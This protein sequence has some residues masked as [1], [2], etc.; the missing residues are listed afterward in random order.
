MA[1]RIFI[2]LVP[3]LFGC[4]SF[5]KP[6]ERLV[7]GLQKWDT[8]DLAGA[9]STFESVCEMGE[10]AACG[11]LGD[12]Q[13]E[14]E[15][16][17][18]ATVS[19]QKGCDSGNSYACYRLGS[20]Y[21]RLGRL[22]EAK[23]LFTKSC[24]EVFNSCVYVGVV[25]LFQQDYTTAKNIFEAQ[26]KNSLP[27]SCLLAG[28]V[29][30][31]NGDYFSAKKFYEKSCALNSLGGCSYLA[32]V[33]FLIGNRD[34]AQLLVESACVNQSGGKACR[35]VELLKV[36][37][38]NRS[39]QTWK[40]QCDKEDRDAC[41]NLGLHKSLS[42]KSLA[43]GKRILKRSCS[44]GSG[45]AC[46]DLGGV[47]T[48]YH[49]SLENRQALV[50]ACNSG[51]ARGCLTI[52]DEFTF[53][54]GRQDYLRKACDLGDGEGCRRIAEHEL[55]TGKREEAKAKYLMACA[56]NDTLACFVRFK[57]FPQNG[58]EQMDGMKSLCNQGLRDGCRFLGDV[59]KK[60]GKI[61]LAAD[62]YGKGCNA[63]DERSCYRQ[64]AMKAKLDLRFD[65]LT[66]Y[67]QLCNHSSGYSCYEA[68]LLLE[69]AGRLV[70]AKPFV[71]RGCYLSDGSSCY[72]QGFIARS[73]K[74]EIKARE[75]YRRA[76]DLG[77]SLG[78]KSM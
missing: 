66:A 53:K 27:E 55:T 5:Q 62:F 15:E 7:S 26:C 32:F 30:E 68:A 29:A 10:R 18:S 60:A 37:K 23:A 28:A 69:E 41:Y 67:T 40:S 65:K 74:N 8:G 11:H 47:L 20:V 25:N 76:C 2:W 34:K 50:A 54:P 33:E 9:Q 39:L 49:Y 46:L 48:S 73:E 43:E 16:I 4:A 72:L 24:A 59:Y 35:V 57:E 12:I 51:S 17:Q 52:D 1:F 70:E 19:F 36:F 78:C 31:N 58:L 56:K 71:E 75:L 45:P 42:R 77:S 3:V 14:K 21:Y 38:G 64:I 61:E 6:Q 22:E 13:L 44:L 63:H